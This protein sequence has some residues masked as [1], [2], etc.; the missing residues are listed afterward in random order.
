MLRAHILWEYADK[1]SSFR[2]ISEIALI[3]IDPFNCISGSIE[4]FEV[5]MIDTVSCVTSDHLIA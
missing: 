5:V 4:T 3:Y 1:F 2:K